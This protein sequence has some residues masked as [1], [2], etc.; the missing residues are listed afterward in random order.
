MTPATRIHQLASRLAAQC[1]PKDEFGD[2]WYGFSGPQLEQFAQAVHDEARNTA[3]DEVIARLQQGFGTA[4]APVTS[5]RRHF[6]T[7]SVQ[8]L[9]AD[10]SEGGNP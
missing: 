9:P 1:L 7:Q 2:G 8:H 6:G 10:D 4:S 5:I 3:L